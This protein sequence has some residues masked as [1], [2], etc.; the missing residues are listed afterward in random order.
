MGHPAP[1]T[2]PGTPPVK[3][4]G[5]MK[6]PPKP[7]AMVN[8]CG[9]GRAG[10]FVGAGPSALPAGVGGSTGVIVAA[11]AMI[12]LR[13][14]AVAATG[15]VDCPA[16]HA[17]RTSSAASSS[18]AGAGAKARSIITVLPSCPRTFHS[19]RRRS[20][21]G[22]HVGF[23]FHAQLAANLRCLRYDTGSEELRRHP[24]PEDARW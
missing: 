24:P 12:G 15:A 16:E 20:S 11:G 23:P 7:D 14:A 18:S 8:V 9:G 2:I 22:R 13:V 3:E 10:Q 17:A 21:R 6:P 1:N 5:P 19:V 4:T